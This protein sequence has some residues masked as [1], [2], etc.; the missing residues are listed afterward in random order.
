MRVEVAKNSD[1]LA[2][3]GLKNPV[4]TRIS[5]LATRLNP[6]K[7]MQVVDFPDIEKNNAQTGGGNF[8]KTAGM[9]CLP[10]NTRMN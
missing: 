10:E 7:A 8:V 9:G 6:L 3:G 1:K 4:L 5:P 2:I